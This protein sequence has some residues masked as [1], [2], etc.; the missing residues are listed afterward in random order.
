MK[1]L[2]L[3][4]A[5]SSSP[6][7]AQWTFKSLHP[8]GGTVS[9]GNGLDVSSQVGNVEIGG[10][11]RAALWHGDA[12]SWT[13]LGPQLPFDGAQAISTGG[14]VQVGFVQFGNETHGCLWRGSPESY[15]DLL[16]IGSQFSFVEATDGLVQVGAIEVDGAAHAV[17]WTGTADS[18]FDMN[19][20]PMRGSWAYG[21]HDDQIVGVVGGS[22]NNAS[23]WTNQ[24]RHWVNLNPPGFLASWAWCT[25]GIQQGGWASIGPGQHA[26]LWS[27]T[28]TTLTFL[29]PAVANLSEVRSMTADEQLGFVYI[30]GQLRPA[31]WS[32]TMG[33]FEDLSGAV[34]SEY[35]DPFLS[36][37]TSTPE[38]TAVVG[39]AT[40]VS[41]GKR[42][43]FILTRPKLNEPVPFQASAFQIVR[44]RIVSGGLSSL[45]Q[46]DGDYLVIRSGVVVNASDPPIQVVIDGVCPNA[47]PARLHALRT[48]S[49]TSPNLRV[50][51]YLYDWQS[52]SWQK[53]DN[54]YAVQFDQFVD[55]PTPDPSRFIRQPDGLVRMKIA[56]SKYGPLSS[57][58]WQARF[59][60]A[61][62][63]QS[64]F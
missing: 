2:L 60:F 62:W 44:G 3:L 58:Q 42:E 20:L 61:G 39:S 57:S 19:P 64:P 45:W 8:G 26:V 9:N 30:D 25:N 63:S 50:E 48:V 33:S 13:D 27:G 43:A 4:A 47:T 52:G 6:A 34:P 18:Y 55:M 36:A 46:Q 56:F 11:S 35:V 15:V 10:I 40:R 14:G 38:F 5:L 1:R 21:I 23:L 12:Q 16:P 53:Q 54:R 29:E 22:V 17:R 41:N 7:M 28:A 31:L 32:G 37:I 59:G 51:G 49:V 24:G